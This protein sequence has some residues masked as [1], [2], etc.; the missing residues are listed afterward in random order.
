MCSVF[1]AVLNI[2]QKL[3]KPTV[4]WLKTLWHEHTIECYPAIKTRMTD[5]FPRH[6]T[7]SKI[8]SQHKM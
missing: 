6:G 5:F 1:T 4:A 8:T 2:K 3:E 7:I